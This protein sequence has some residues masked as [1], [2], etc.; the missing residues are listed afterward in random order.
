MATPNKWAVRS[1]ARA[2][3]Y[4]LVT[5]NA[6]AYLDTLKTS[7]VNTTSETSYAR[8]GD[9]NVKLVGFS[10]NKESRI[11]LED[12]IFDNSVLGMLT[13]NDVVTGIAQEIYKRDIVEVVAGKATL[14]KTPKGDLLSVYVLKADGTHDELL[15]EGVASV[16]EDAY[17]LT[18]KEITVDSAL[19]GKKIAVYY[20]VESDTTATEIKVTS[21]AFGGSFKLVLD[22]LVRD[23][24][25]KKDFAAQLIIPNGKIED[26]WEFSFTPDGDPATLS[27]PIEV[28]RDPSST[29]MWTMKIYD[30][31]L[32][33]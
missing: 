2:T 16:D 12:A 1:V 21:D 9:G 28:L 32:I 14:S 25:T 5:N 26:E 6:I 33:Q 19:N 24:Y 8:G 29:D 17:E 7:G 23:Y 30:D 10:S 22:V 27:I 4:D 20:M 31:S 18:G 3:F 15:T 13:G 11:T